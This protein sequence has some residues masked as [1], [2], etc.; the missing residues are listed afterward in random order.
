MRVLLMNAEGIGHDDYLAAQQ[1][2]VSLRAAAEDVLSN[3]DAVLAP[4]SRIV[5]P[6]IG[7]RWNAADFTDYTRP[8]STTGHPV[9]SL[10]LPGSGC[11]VGSRASA[12]WEV[13]L[14]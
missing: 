12:G 5:A 2:A 10:P 8:F 3:W 13:K 14:I 9:I 7:G 11:Q 1:S 6:L 4:V